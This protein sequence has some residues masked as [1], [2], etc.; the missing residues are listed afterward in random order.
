MVWNMRMRWRTA[1]LVVGMLIV[2][3]GVAVAV[4]VNWPASV[5]G[6]DGWNG[7]KLVKGARC[8]VCYSLVIPKTLGLKNEKQLRLL[9][10]ITKKRSEMNYDLDGP[11]FDDRDVL[12]HLLRLALAYRD[13]LAGR[14]ILNPEK[15]G[16]AVGVE[17]SEDIEETH[18]VPLIRGYDDLNALIDGKDYEMLA[19]RICGWSE[20]NQD[21]RVANDLITELK[22]RQFGSFADLLSS[23]CKAKKEFMKNHGENFVE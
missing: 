4:S 1:L 3:S 9:I 11:L 7:M 17:T 10:E 15:Y 13:A 14:V 16:M 21:F 5:S 8:P 6:L 2:I 12:D 18:I 20:Q 22:K 23:S 19:R